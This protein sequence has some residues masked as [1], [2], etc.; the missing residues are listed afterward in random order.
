MNLMITIFGQNIINTH[1]DLHC[2]DVVV[3]LLS[4]FVAQ[5]SKTARRKT[6]CKCKKHV[7]S[8]ISVL[9]QPEEAHWPDQNSWVIMAA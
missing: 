1:E 3:E 4:L 5:L 6:N 9:C 2:G 8:Y 7:S